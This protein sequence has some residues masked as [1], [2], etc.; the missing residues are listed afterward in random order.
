MDE[1]VVPLS[2]KN[3]PLL[4]VVADV[5]VDPKSKQGDDNI[6]IIIWSSVVKRLSHQT[7]C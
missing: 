7:F 1:R 6:Q 5:G 4:L 2:G 3:L